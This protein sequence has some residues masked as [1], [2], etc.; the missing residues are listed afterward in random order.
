MSRHERWPNAIHLAAVR[1]HVDVAQFLYTESFIGC[2]EETV[3]AARN[4]HLLAVKWLY[5][6]YSNTTLG[7]LFP[8]PQQ[9]SELVQEFMCA[10]D[11]AASNGHLKVLQFLHGLDK[12][13][14]L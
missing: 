13:S 9:N 14:H 2:G 10:M 12:G 8:K 4:G 6:H 5:K 1:G 7:G 11:A 3:T